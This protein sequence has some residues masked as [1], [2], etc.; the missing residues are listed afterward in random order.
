MKF[1]PA[2]L[3]ALGLTV[4]DGS[5]C[6]AQQ[7]GQTVQGRGM[8]GLILEG[9]TLTDAQKTQQRAIREKYAPQLMQLRKTAQ[10][11]GT[12]IDQVKLAEIRAAQVSELRAILTAEQVAT[13]DRNVATLKARTPERPGNR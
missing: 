8:G 7:A 11:T 2:A 12:P 3:L 9:I 6:V 4:A 13:F 10:T 5:A 1:L